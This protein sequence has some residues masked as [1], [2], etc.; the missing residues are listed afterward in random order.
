MASDC[1]RAVGTRRGSPRRAC[2]CSPR[3]AHYPPSLP[4]GTRAAPPRLVARGALAAARA[5][6]GLF[7]RVAAG[8]C[9]RYGA[10]A[11]GRATRLESPSGAGLAARRDMQLWGS[12]RRSACLMTRLMGL[13]ITSG[14]LVVTSPVTRYLIA[15]TKLGSPPRVAC[16]CASR[17]GRRRKAGTRISHETLRT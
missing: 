11:A 1:R 10:G 17:A 4:T 3:R 5:R 7:H 2:K 8:P 12:S 9:A 13:F 14:H 6:T 16:T 15:N